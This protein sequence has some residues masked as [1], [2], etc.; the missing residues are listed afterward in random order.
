MVPH[1]SAP[2]KLLLYNK[3]QIDVLIRPGERTRY[4]ADSAPGDREI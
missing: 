2:L 4:H 1:S 3:L